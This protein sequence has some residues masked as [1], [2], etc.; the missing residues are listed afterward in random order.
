MLGSYSARE[1]LFEATHTLIGPSTTLICL[2]NPPC[3]VG[4]QLIG[5]Y[6]PF[7]IMCLLFMSEIELKHKAVVLIVS[8]NFS[9]MRNHEIDYNVMTHLTK[10]A[11]RT[12]THK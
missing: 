8:N 11:L 7:C 4:R 3:E 1:D 2:I 10:I 12:T 9:P 6:W 5:K